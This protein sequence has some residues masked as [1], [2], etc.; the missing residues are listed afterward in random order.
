[1]QTDH[2]LGFGGGNPIFRVADV[3]ASAAYYVEKLGFTIDWT[4]GDVCC[5]RA[6]QF[7]LFLVEGDQGQPG[8]WAWLGVSDVRALREHYR[9][10]GAQIRH[11]PT[12]YAW[13]LEMQVEDLDGNVLRVGS[14]R[15]AGEPDGEWLD[16]RGQVWRQSPEG[17]WRRVSGAAPVVG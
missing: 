11:E 4:A 2:P 10:T 17:H 13:A 8:A 9:R 5:V 7:T 14:E 6:H 1:M 3:E 12:N 15:D 16:M